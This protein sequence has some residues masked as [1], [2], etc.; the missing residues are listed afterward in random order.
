MSPAP[1]PSTLGAAPPVPLASAFVQLFEWKWTD[2]ALECENYLGPAGFAGVQVSPPSEH[3]VIAGYPWW[4][5]YQ[6]VSYS[7]ARSRSGTLSEFEDMVH[8][9]ALGGVRVYVDA[10]F[11][12]M[13]AQ[14]EGTGYNG[15]QYTKYSYP[16]LFAETDFHEPPCVIQPSDYQDS[17]DH[18]R[19]C[20]LDG[21]ADLKTSD[22]GVR[23]KIAGYLESMVDIGVLGFRVDAAKHM[24][25][26]D[27]DAIVSRVNQHAGPERLPF[28]FF[29][30]TGT[31]GEAVNAPDYLSVGA[32]SGQAVSVTDFK[33]ASLF[34]Q[35]ATAPQI[36][37]LKALQEPGADYLPSAQA[38]VFTTN[39]DTERDSPPHAVMYQDGKAYDLATVF[40]LA[41]PYGYPVLMSS[42]A[43]DRTTSAGLAQGP[44]SD[45][46]GNT[47]A[48]YPSGSSTP[49]CSSDPA[50]APIGTWV[51][52]HRE[53][54][55][56]RMLA[57]R[58]AVAQE[59]EVINFWDD[60]DNQIAFGRGSQGFVVINR[61]D[62]PLMQVLPTSLPAGSYCEVFTGDKSGG[63]CSGVT[64]SVDSSGMATFNVPSMGAAVIHAGSRL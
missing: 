59:S 13:T 5:R 14:T 63:A 35:F 45:A 9:C 23:E 12:H 10:V 37:S 29:E 19:I 2:I 47:L 22:D 27:L 24:Y 58:K 54:F 4:E 44:P 36:A 51:C 40:L 30:V 1:P 42:F 34:D 8:R 11:N 18:V 56:A 62:T 3:A 6:T 60:G 48:I 39:H 7:L 43:F 26:G 38:V 50:T 20:E 57:F 52:Q 21:L 28:F 15:T 33:Y 49:S 31:G 16:G 17:A 46:M 41:W 25:P 61:S 55:V 53:P 64:V 32:S